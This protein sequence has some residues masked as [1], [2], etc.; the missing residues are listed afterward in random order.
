MIDKEKITSEWIEKVSKANR[1]VV[2]GFSF[3]SAMKKPL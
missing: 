2:P 3:G 1:N